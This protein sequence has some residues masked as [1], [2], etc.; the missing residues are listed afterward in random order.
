VRYFLEQLPTIH[1]VL[2]AGDAALAYDHG[3]GSKP[4]ALSAPLEHAVVDG[5]AP[6]P[7]Q[8]VVAYA[9]KRDAELIASALNHLH[10]DFREPVLLSK[11]AGTS[12]G[13]TIID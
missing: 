9:T 12:T 13:T 3:T 6:H 4:G 10:H 5:G 8:R 11:H 2:K 1:P 7:K